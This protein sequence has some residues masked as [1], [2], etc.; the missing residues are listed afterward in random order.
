MIYTTDSIFKNTKYTLDSLLNETKNKTYD[1][2]I[3]GI[4]QELR[5]S[6]GK[7]MKWIFQNCRVKLLNNK[8]P[9]EPKKRG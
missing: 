1:K 7:A 3:V 4:F 8:K 5:S 6:L 9:D 2:D